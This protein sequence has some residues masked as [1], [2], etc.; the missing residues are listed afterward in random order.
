MVA[1]ALLTMATIKCDKIFL[2]QSN[3]KSSQKEMMMHYLVIV[4]LSSSNIHVCAKLK[5][6]EIHL[7]GEE[8][9]QFVCKM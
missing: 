7:F 6:I 3:C 5:L 1:V 2:F 4:T 9:S 8:S